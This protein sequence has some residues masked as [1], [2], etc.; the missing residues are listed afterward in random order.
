MHCFFLIFFVVGCDGSILFSWFGLRTSPPPQLPSTPPPPTTRLSSSP[1]RL[2]S[3][4]AMSSSDVRRKKILYLH[5]FEESPDSMKPAHIRDS[6]RY[7]FHYVNLGMYLTRR[8]SPILYGLTSDVALGSAA[9]GVAAGF[10]A[11]SIP[12]GVV[13]CVTLLA[14]LRKRLLGKAVSG[15][16]AATR[17]EALAAAVRLQPDAI[18]GFSWGGAV[19]LDLLHR[20]DLRDTPCLLLSPAHLLIAGLIHG[21]PA[22]DAPDAAC[23]PPTKPLTGGKLAVIHSA[24]DTLVPIAHSEMLVGLQ[25]ASSV[26]HRVDGEGHKL[27]G[28]CSTGLLLNAL[29]GV[30]QES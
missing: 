2:F 13:V 27:W 6:A 20:T 5:G 29:D 8:H 18:V 4:R 17:Q 3:S 28:T 26:L 16:Y 23:A 9:A 12:V 22:A 14:L 30:L 25:P 10:L 1:S 11:A 21:M 7:D 24:D 19:A 15:A